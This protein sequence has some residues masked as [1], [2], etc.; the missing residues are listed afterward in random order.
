MPL[1]AGNF[2]YIGASDLVP[3]VNKGHSLPTSVVHFACFLA[4]LGGLYAL[5]ALGH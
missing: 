3:E 4:G 5:T 1:A 2:L